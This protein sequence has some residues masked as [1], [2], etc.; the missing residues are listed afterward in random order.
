MPRLVLRSPVVQHSY[1]SEGNNDQALAE[2]DVDTY[3]HLQAATTQ[4]TLVGN[5]VD[6]HDPLQATRSATRLATTPR[7]PLS[8]MK[9]VP[10]S[11]W[12]TVPPSSQQEGLLSSEPHTRTP[13]EAGRDAAS[14]LAPFGFDPITQRRAQL[15]FEPASGS[16]RLEDLAAQLK[17]YEL[18]TELEQAGLK[19]TTARIASQKA[20]NEL[21]QLQ[22][23]STPQH[24]RPPSPTHGNSPQQPYPSADVVEVLAALATSLA[25][26]TSGNSLT[27]PVWSPKPG[28]VMKDFPIFTGNL[29]VDLKPVE[30][31]ARDFEEQAQLRGLLQQKESVVVAELILRLGGEALRWHRTFVAGYQITHGLSLDAYAPLQVT[32]TQL[33]HRFSEPWSTWAS[34]HASQ[35]PQRAKNS[36]GLSALQQLTDVRRRLDA[37]GVPQTIG[38]NEQ[39]FVLMMSI[40]TPVER[41]AWTQQANGDPTISEQALA[42]LEGQST[43]ALCRRE[44]LP[45]REALATREDLFE[46]RC[47][48]LEVYLTASPGTSSVTVARAAPLQETTPFVSAAAVAPAPDAGPPAVEQLYAL[49][50]E[51]SA[52]LCAIIDGRHVREARSTLSPQ[53]RTPTPFPEYFG[54]TEAEKNKAEFVRRREGKLCYA[55]NRTPHQGQDPKTGDTW[56]FVLCPHHGPMASL[57]AQ[58]AAKMWSVKGAGLRNGKKAH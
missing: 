29:Q 27:V 51:L 1:G 21:Q 28:S 5:D 52:T 6:T 50:E 42:D 17:G 2:D 53:N 54:A 44:S 8:S 18:E 15:Q 45:T 4:L 20:E 41:L 40:A 38:S 26:L 31:W 23:C 58:A 35:N 30:E 55:C 25:R 10:P 12:R 19:L 56:K 13:S 22:S 24:S 39:R 14:R 49:H 11:A 7:R 47:R 37:H 32:I 43:G 9:P 33:I 46:R 48:S 16:T 3:D 36:S 34:V 57:P